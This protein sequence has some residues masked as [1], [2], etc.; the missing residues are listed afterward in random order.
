MLSN[1]Y[2]LAKIRFDTAENEPAKN[3]Q[4]FANFC[5]KISKFSCKNCVVQFSATRKN[6][7][8][9]GGRRSRGRR[10]DEPPVPDPVLE[11][12]GR[13]PVRRAV[14]EDHLNVGKIGKFYKIL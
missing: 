7:L 11:P 14:R 1:A 13:V 2:F 10:R 4:K 3:L 6:R 12:D 5:K 8:P 9:S